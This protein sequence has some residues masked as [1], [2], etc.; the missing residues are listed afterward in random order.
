MPLPGPR[1]PGRGR[2][3][4]TMTGSR[5]YDKIL[6]G[7]ACAIET[8][9]LACEKFRLDLGSRGA[10][11][12]REC[13][14]LCVAAHRSFQRHHVLTA[15]RLFATPL[16]L[17]VDVTRALASVSTEQAQPRLPMKCGDRR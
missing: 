3:S 8:E 15:R 14:E 5:C 17:A 2:F 1:G 10:D 4:R 16:C 13:G 12:K 11:R 6:N 9:A 7:T